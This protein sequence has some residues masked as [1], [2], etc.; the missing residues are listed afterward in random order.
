MDDPQQLVRESARVLSP[1]GVAFYLSPNKYSLYIEPHFR[2]VGF[3][4][5]PMPVR[6]MLARRYSGA[7]SF[8]GT[9]LRSLGEL[10]RWGRTYFTRPHLYMIPRRL[11]TTARGGVLRWA[12]RTGLSMRGVGTLID[13]IMNRLLLPLMPYHVMVAL[14]PRLPPSSHGSEDGA[15]SRAKER[16]G[17]E[18]DQY[19]AP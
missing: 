13:L 18:M 2:V 5:W 8:A 10:R 12:I 6:R 15:F 4:F 11:D 19:A 3:G 14:Q 9:R 16:S 1:E 17:D 7:T